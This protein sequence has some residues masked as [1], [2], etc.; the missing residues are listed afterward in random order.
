[1]SPFTL[2]HIWPGQVFPPFPLT[3]IFCSFIYFFCVFPAAQDAPEMGRTIHK[4][5]QNSPWRLW[6]NRRH[7]VWL[8]AINLKSASCPPSFFSG[9]ARLAAPAV[10][11]VSPPAPP[12]PA[13][14]YRKW[15]NFWNI[16]VLRVYSTPDENNGYLRP[17]FFFLMLLFL[18]LLPLLHPSQAGGCLR[19][20]VLRIKE[21]Y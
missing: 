8:P 17:C 9:P 3:H 4:G 13:A 2:T 20:K 18:L 1:M 11:P 6:P 21:V 16:K 14:G 7:F 15:N 19:I 5:S 10:A 12:A